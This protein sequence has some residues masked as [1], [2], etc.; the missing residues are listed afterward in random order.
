ML[1]AL[2][3]DDL[4]QQKWSERCKAK[5]LPEEASSAGLFLII[6]NQPHSFRR[7]RKDRHARIVQVSVK[8]YITQEN[9]SREY[10][11][12]ENVVISEARFD[13]V[14][15]VSMAQNLYCPKLHK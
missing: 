6:N 2:Q 10:G 3:W 11:W 15:L 8:N 4:V 9:V 7:V 14:L 13:R 1:I 12:E 5:M